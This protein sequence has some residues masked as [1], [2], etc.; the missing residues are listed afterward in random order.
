M[1]GLKE[2]TVVARDRVGLLAD[3]SEILSGR[4]IN[5]DSVS[6]ETSARTAI[7]RILVHDTHTAKKTLEA[8]GFKVVEAG[9]LVI[10]LPD[11]PG[12]LAK[13]SRIL[14][15]KKIMIESAFIL[16]KEGEKTVLSLKVDNYSAAKKLL[17]E[18]RY[19]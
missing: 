15:N 6:V 19:I 10:G 1:D 13:M 7:I 2:I 9:V 18:N 4:N 11:Q 16:S 14:A 5:I 3:I 12:E 17:R 8:A